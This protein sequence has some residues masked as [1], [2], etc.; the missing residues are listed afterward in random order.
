MSIF[1]V[2]LRG[3]SMTNKSKDLFQTRIDQQIKAERD[4][5]HK[6]NKKK[7]KN[8]IGTIMSIIIGGS[9]I[10]GLLRILVMLF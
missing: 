5:N 2:R 1:L 7:P 10:F 6:S 9:V 3:F 8:I 4:R